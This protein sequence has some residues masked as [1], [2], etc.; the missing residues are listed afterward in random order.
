MALNLSRNSRVFLTTNVD[1][2]G[3]VQETAS[4]GFTAANTYEIQVLDGFTFS[5]NTNT[6]AVTLNE[7]GATPVRGQRT[8]NTSLA[9]VDF[10]FS[11]YVRP[12]KST[13]VLAEESVLWG[14]LLNNPTSSTSFTN[15]GFNTSG[16]TNSTFTLAN[17]NSNQLTKFGMIMIIDQ[18]TYVIDN[19]A[20][21]QAVLDFS[22]DQISTLQWSGFGAAI[23]QLTANLVATTGT[24]T[25][26]GVTGTSN[27]TQKN[28]SAAFIAN[29]LSTVKITGNTPSISQFTL[30][31]TGGSLTYNNNITYLTPSNLA[32]VN[33]PTTYFT[34]TRAISGSFTA[35]LRTGST[36]DAGYLLSQMLAATSTTETDFALVVDVGGA[37]ATTKVTLNMPHCSVQIPSID[38]Q[39]VVTTTINFT[40]QGYSGSS[41]DLAATSDL[42]IT[43]TAP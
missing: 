34:G 15:A 11:T 12:R 10:S 41:Y 29:K 17:T 9:P 40:A 22:I 3:K 25:G 28:T 32:V 14:V 30:P 20:M 31:I 36:S 2:A 8:F 42:D 38:V 37:S 6:E 35:Y 7:A 5:Q 1:S 33:V 13:N 24:F 23:R 27:Y 26:G 21:N 4:N 16:T 18:V 39:Q 19:C 43:Y